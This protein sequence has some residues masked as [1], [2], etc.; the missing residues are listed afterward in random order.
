MRKDGIWL[1]DKELIGDIKIDD[2]KLFCDLQQNCISSN[3]KCESMEN[4]EDKLNE[5][6][7]N[8]IYKEFDETYS[9]ADSNTRDEVEKNL[10]LSLERVKLLKNIKI[11]EYFKYDILKRKYG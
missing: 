9:E 8:K 11:A 1:Q 10:L 2:N 4:V 5:D 6:T 3:D 7:L